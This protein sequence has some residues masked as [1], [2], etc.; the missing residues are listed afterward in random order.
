VV[1]ETSRGKATVKELC[2]L[3]K[4][5]R[6]AY[7]AARKRLNEEPAERPRKRQERK[8]DWATHEE[9]VAAIREV[10]DER[11]AWGVRKVWATLRRRGVVA[12]HKRVWAVMHD[13]GLVLPPI[14][15]REYPAKRGH[16]TVPE[17]NRRWATD[18][19]TVW[20]RKDGL[21][22]VMPVVDCGDRCTLAIHATKSQEAP[23][24]LVPVARAFEEQF[25]SPA[26]V[27]D[28]LELRTDNG[29]QYTS[30]ACEDL[31]D[32]WSV[33]QTFS[34]PGRPTG[35]AVAERLIQTL[36]VE[37]IWLRDWESLEELQEALEAWRR[38]YNTERPHQ[39]LGWQTPAEK[40]A[41][42]LGRG[43]RR[44]AAA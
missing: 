5:S 31:C 13:L 18:L 16:V 20:T 38:D 32:M 30:A 26:N 44:K 29:P 43:P 7:Y 35:N 42:N 17:S 10:V 33:E 39:S 36:K 12:S 1:R 25:G 24:V 27:P 22:A 19:T 4:I 41:A 28:G 14:S 21:V 3:F 11:P 2:A 40:R 23:Y 6:Q 8:G 9:L 37:L 34:P 15:E